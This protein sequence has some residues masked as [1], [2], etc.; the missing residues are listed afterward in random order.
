LG[1]CFLTDPSILNR[2]VEIAGIS[3][4]SDVLEVGPGPGTLTSALLQ[5]GAVVSAIEIDERAVSHLA[6]NLAHPNLTVINGNA[7]KVAF[8]QERDAKS[9]RKNHIFVGNLPYNLSTQ[10]FF[11]FERLSTIS[12]MALMFQLEVARRFVAEPGSK[13]YGPLAILSAI[14]WRPELALKLPPGA[15]FPAP[16][17]HSAVV[18]YTRLPSAIV[19]PEREDRMRQLVR[20]A[21][22]KRRK[23]LRNAVAGEASVDQIKRAGIDPS[24]RPEQVPVSSWV[25]LAEQE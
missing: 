25:R 8:P 9:Q 21:F 15:F 24:T 19:A 22:Q 7:L 16:K 5:K 18:H 3:D 6:E 2:I 14:R 1:Q 10:I 17:V 20:K 12:R 23:T 11:R 4:G 13:S